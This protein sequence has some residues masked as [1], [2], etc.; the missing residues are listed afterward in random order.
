MLLQEKIKKLEEEL[1]LTPKNKAT[2]VHV[3]NLKSRIAELRREMKKAGSKKRSRA[4]GIR[5]TGDASVVL[6]GDKHEKEDLMG[7]LTNSIH[8]VGTL[9]YKGANI[10]ILCPSKEQEEAASHSSDLVIASKELKG[11]EIKGVKEVIFGRLGLIR[12]YTKKP[13]KQADLQHPMI[14]GKGVKI[15]DICMK[16]FRT[17]KDFKYAR[18]WGPS[19]KFS[20]GQM[21]GLNHQLCDEDIV[22]IHLS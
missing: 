13:G 2:E 19:S 7:K 10:Q 18:I 14:M 1:K 8:A 20:T 12:L 21:V 9:R 3:Q 16:L 15:S 6:I 22:E 17:T 5:K 11:M 4:K